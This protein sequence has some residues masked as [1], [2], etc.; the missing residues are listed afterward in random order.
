[1][2]DGDKK[3]I[4]GVEFIFVSNKATK[5]RLINL[6]SR[7][8]LYGQKSGIGEAEEK[9]TNSISKLEAIVK[10]FKKFLS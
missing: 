5:K 7:Y 3:I 6:N 8:G 4:D 10:G 9:L 1:M 2:R